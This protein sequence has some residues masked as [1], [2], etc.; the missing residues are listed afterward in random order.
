MFLLA[1]NAIGYQSGG[2]R[3]RPGKEKKKKRTWTVCHTEKAENR[4]AGKL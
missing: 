4:S 3:Q 1:E 2:Q